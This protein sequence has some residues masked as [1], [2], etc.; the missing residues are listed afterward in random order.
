[1]VVMAVGPCMLGKALT[2]ADVAD[3]VLTST[4]VARA[5]ERSPCAAEQ[6]KVLACLV[7]LIVSALAD[8]S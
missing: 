6:E 7:C 2:G 3:E 4:G 8:L 5:T 1:M